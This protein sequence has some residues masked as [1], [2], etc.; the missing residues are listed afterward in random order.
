MVQVPVRGQALLQ[1]HREVPGNA[2]EKHLLPPSLLVRA[3]LFPF[4]EVLTHWRSPLAVVLVEV[5]LAVEEHEPEEGL[6]HELHDSQAD[7]NEVAEHR[8]MVADSREEVG[9]P[10]EDEEASH[11]VEHLELGATCAVECPVV[12]VVF[13]AAVAEEAVLEHQ[14]GACHRWRRLHLQRLS[15]EHGCGHGCWARPGE[16]PSPL[17]RESHGHDGESDFGYCSGLCQPLT[18][19]VRTYQ[20]FSITAVVFSRASARP[21]PRQRH[22]PPSQT[23]VQLAQR[24]QRGH[25]QC[26]QHASLLLPS[27]SYEQGSDCGCGQG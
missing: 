26:R 20:A 9:L 17:L 6:V 4:A 19:V 27:A 22:H 10:T 16:L 8:E 1:V 2:S 24:V 15:Q 23:S 7:A 13:A 14:A 25:Q 3:L 11:H 12:V 18:F 21:S 5:A